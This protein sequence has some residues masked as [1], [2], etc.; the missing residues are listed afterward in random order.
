M[1]RTTLV[2]IMGFSFW[3]L[4]GQTNKFKTVDVDVFETF[5]KD[6]YTRIA[7]RI[8]AE[9]GYEVVDKIVRWILE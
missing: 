1:K 2:L 6:T 8:L 9:R 4:F 7:A 3:G 5:I